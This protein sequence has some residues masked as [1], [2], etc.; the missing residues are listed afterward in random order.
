MEVSQWRQLWMEQKTPDIIEIDNEI[1]K[2]YEIDVRRNYPVLAQ[3]LKAASRIL[4]IFGLNYAQLDTNDL[5]RLGRI[6]ERE[7]NDEAKEF[8]K[9][10]WTSEPTF[11]DRIFKYHMVLG[12]TDKVVILITLR[13]LQLMLNT[14]NIPVPAHP[15]V[16]IKPV[17]GCESP[18]RQRR[19]ELERQ[20]ALQ[21]W[22]DQ[23]YLRML[24]FM[25]QDP[26]MVSNYG[27]KVDDFVKANPIYNRQLS[28]EQNKLFKKFKVD[29]E[30]MPGQS[31]DPLRKMGDEIPEIFKS[32]NPRDT[33]SILYRQL[34]YFQARQLLDEGTVEGLMELKPWALDKLFGSFRLKLDDQMKSCLRQWAQLYTEEATFIDDGRRSTRYQYSILRLQSFERLVQGAIQDRI[35]RDPDHE[36]S[37][38]E[39]YF[40]RPQDPAIDLERAIVKTIKSCLNCGKDAFLQCGGCVDASVAYCG[41]S[42]QSAHWKEI[43]GKACQKSHLK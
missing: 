7:E 14:F 24:A 9:S 13:Q 4:G 35:R 29:F 20:R 41:V 22:A 23:K 16:R 38:E 17:G 40:M 19:D 18:E 26:W 25:R 10:L 12:G 30:S 39:L 3:R 34:V 1:A 43:H 2:I 11:Y 21:I 32:N 15:F 31:A 36:L 6:L 28:L 5:A 33:W 27:R 42:C 37:K 8:L